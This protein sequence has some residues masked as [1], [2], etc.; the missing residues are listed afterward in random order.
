MLLEM[1]VVVSEVLNADLSIIPIK[2]A[3]TILL[4]TASVLGN[5][6]TDAPFVEKPID[7]KLGTWS[8]V[9]KIR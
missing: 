1:R 9:G 2:K 6:I 7:S 8:L 3:P 5:P 4:I